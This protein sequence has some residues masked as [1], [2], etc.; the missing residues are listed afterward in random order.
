MA[1]RS[2]QE[3]NLHYLASI[4][5]MVKE[6]IT[7]RRDQG[8]T[9]NIEQNV[10]A[11]QALLKSNEGIYNR[12]KGHIESGTDEKTTFTKAN[13]T[14]V[15][16]HHD[17]VTSM[18]QFVTYP[19]QCRLE[20]DTSPLS[21]VP[22]SLKVGDVSFGLRYIGSVDSNESSFI[23]YTALFKSLIMLYD[24]MLGPYLV[25]LK[26]HLETVHTCLTKIDDWLS[27]P[28]S[29]M[30]YLQQT[31]G[32]EK[33]QVSN[34]TIKH[35][36]IE[37]SHQDNEVC[38]QCEGRFDQHNVEERKVTSIEGGHRR[39]CPHPED[40]DL[41]YFMCSK[42]DADSES[43][44]P[45]YRVEALYVLREFNCSGTFGATFDI[46]E[47]KG[48]AQLENFVKFIVSIAE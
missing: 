43:Q 40:K 26:N 5:S 3:D 19:D 30:G 38:F 32:E 15:D 36:C 18:F 9:G 46:S 7:D 39:L 34:K 48:C 12:C 6:Q 29:N 33:L 41:P 47:A 14:V 11:I 13:H 2:T 1:D 42:C 17:E 21:F 35:F 10:R 24:D 28:S 44:C 8:V 45:H 23:D 25:K 4:R 37:G 31:F 16:A 27:V 22:F 20:F